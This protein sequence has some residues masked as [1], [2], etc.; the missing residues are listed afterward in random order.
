MKDTV[1]SIKG[2]LV[3][4]DVSYQDTAAIKQDIAQL[5]GESR[6]E[7]ED[8][9]LKKLKNDMFGRKEKIQQSSLALLR[10]LA[11]VVSAR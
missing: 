2:D 5:V 6:A 7:L 10:S 11:D 1:S 8:V 9:G 4:L 3:G